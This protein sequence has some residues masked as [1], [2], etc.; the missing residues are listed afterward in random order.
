MAE[1]VLSEARKEFRNTGYMYLSFYFQGYGILPILLPRIWDTVFN[2]FV[3]FQGYRL[4][5]KINGYLPVYHAHL[6]VYFKG[7]PSPIQA[8]LV[9]KVNK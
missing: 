4:F 2:N 8:P 6:L 1:I 3:H 9:L 7:T 5:R